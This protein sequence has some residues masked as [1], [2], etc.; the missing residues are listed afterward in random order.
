MNQIEK[1]R[2]EAAKEA[3][4]K[5]R[6]TIMSQKIAE[7]EGIE[8]TND[9]LAAQVDALAQTYNTTP[10]K[11]IQRIREFDGVG[12]MMAEILSIK[13]IQA[14]TQGRKGTGGTINSETES[15][16]ADAAKIASNPESK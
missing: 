9:D 4:R 16:N 3:E 12:P 10:A 8:V 14:I 1:Y 11:V 6:W 7:K 2:P 13:V 5:V 15:V